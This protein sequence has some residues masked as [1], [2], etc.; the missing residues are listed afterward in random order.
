MFFHGSSR[1][2]SKE[3]G[4]ILSKNDF[5][6]LDGVLTPSF[7][8]IEKERATALATVAIHLVSFFRFVFSFISCLSSY[9]EKKGT[10]SVLRIWCTKVSLMCLHV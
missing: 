10:G 7:P 9:F 1:L 6:K 8:R 5:E 3:T 2:G 4:F